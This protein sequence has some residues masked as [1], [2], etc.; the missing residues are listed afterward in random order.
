MAS[1]GAE[2][3]MSRFGV[4][5]IKIWDMLSLICLLEIQGEIFNR[6]MDK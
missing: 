6:K 3:V 2:M 5:K 4:K 1:G